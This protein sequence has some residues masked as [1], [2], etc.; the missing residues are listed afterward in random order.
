MSIR[1]ASVTLVGLGLLFVLGGPAE[2]ALVGYW[3]FDA[4]SGGT[5][6]DAS[7]GG[8]N[9]TIN[10][11]SWVTAD[12]LRGTALSFDGNDYV[13]MGD[14]NYPV[15]NA[16]TVAAW[17]YS[18]ENDGHIVN[19]GGG[20]SDD[21][22]TIFWC[23]DPNPD[24]IR[25]ELQNG[26]KVMSDN[27]APSQDAWHYVAFT[28]DQNGDKRIRTYIDGTLMGNQPVF[29]GPIGDPDQNLNVGRNAAHDRYLSGMIDDVAIWDEALEPWQ[30]SN[31]MRLG[32]DQYNVP[33]PTT[34]LVWSLLA[35]LG[36]GCGAHRRKR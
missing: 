30:L 23:R 17:A 7:S 24:A 10:G 5:A 33:E 16:I 26:S 28:W 25:I 12:P 9:G 6:F 32:A 29:N 27:T 11:A 20:W 2:A 4:G 31:A 3:P 35:A 13:D 1:N 34:L 21:G 22:Y 18:T 19:Q 14:R 8:H 15:A 36:I